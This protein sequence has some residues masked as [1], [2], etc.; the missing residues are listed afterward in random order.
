[1]EV[2]NTYTEVFSFTQEDVIKFAELSG[3][4]NPVHLDAEFAANTTFKRPIIHGVLG[5]S[6]FSKIMGMDFPGEGTIILKQDLSFKRPM[7]VD[8]LY[9]AVISIAE[10]NKERHQLVMDTKIIDNESGKANLTGQVWVMNK[11]KVV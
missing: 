1:M 10:I 7:Y 2:G 5:M 6:I 3:D 8:T 9:K 4:S 11:S